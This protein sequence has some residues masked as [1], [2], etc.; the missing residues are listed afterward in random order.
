[1]KY[2]HA[3]LHMDLFYKLIFCNYLWNDLFAQMYN[4][5]LQ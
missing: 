5:Y 2:P 3:F 4:N 1:M